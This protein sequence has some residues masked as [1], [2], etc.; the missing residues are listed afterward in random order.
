LLLAELIAEAGV[1][2]GAFNV[3][4]GFGDTG[5]ALSAHDAVD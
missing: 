1:P 4:T 2:D 3:L 5:A